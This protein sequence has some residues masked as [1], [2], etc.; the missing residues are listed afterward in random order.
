MTSVL[1]SPPTMM[2]IADCRDLVAD[3]MALVDELIQSRLRSEV[4]LVNSLSGYIIAGGGKR[5]RPQLVLL[6]AGACAYRGRQHIDTAAIVEF[7]HTATL[8]HDDVVDASDLRRG[9]DT[10]NAVW[11]NE[12]AV[13][14]GDFLYSR[15]FEMMVRVG[16]MRVMEILSATTNRIAEGEVMQLMHVNDASLTVEGYTEVIRAKTARLFE[17]AVQLA[18]VLA[19]VDER[20]EQALA[21]YGNHL[22]VAFQ[23]TDDVLDYRGDSGAL[24]KQVGDDLAEGKPTLPLILAMRDGTVAQAR[25]I[26]EAINNG[27]RDR[28]DDVLGVIEATD[29]LDKS[30][31]YA[32][33]EVDRAIAMIDTLQASEY[34][35]ALRC[36]ARYSLE[37]VN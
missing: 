10:A 21:D 18:G 36:I 6:A 1:S 13:L 28:I 2:D 26:E 7:I 17:A 30:M 29:A 20:R 22:G 25:V 27:G 32:G 35:D 8:L 33:A 11:G 9:Q 37:R 12:A 4:A 3:E 34:R 5:L 31:Q 23:I 24:G 15:S 19:G 16:S 14:V